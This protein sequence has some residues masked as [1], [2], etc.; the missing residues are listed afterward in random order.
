MRP[1]ASIIIPL[2][3]LLLAGSHALA[4][5]IIGSVD[6][7][8][9]VTFS[10]HVPAG[11]VKS[12]EVKVD[13]IYPSQESLEATRETTQQMIDAADQSREDLE[14]VRK[15]REELAEKRRSR[16]EADQQRTQEAIVVPPGDGYVIDDESYTPEYQDYFEQLQEIESE[17]SAPSRL[18]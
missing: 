15:T 9:N 5:K 12:R 7:K 16:M 14:N 13:P 8:G 4:E 1:L 17:A 18:D 2:S 11:A 10:D 3:L 6:Q